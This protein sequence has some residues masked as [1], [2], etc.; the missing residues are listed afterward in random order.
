MTPEDII[1]SLGLIPHPEG[2]WYTETW[3]SDPEHGHRSAGTAIYFLL[4]A[5]E[6]SHWHRVDADETWHHYAGGPLELLIAPTVNGPAT[7]HILTGDLTMGRPQAVVPKGHWQAAQ[8][9]GDW[10][11]VGCTVSPGF[12]FAGFDLAMPDFDIP[13]ALPL[14]RGLPEGQRMR[15]AALFWDAFK[16]KLGPILGPRDKALAFLAPALQP[17]FAISALGTRGQLLGIA[18]IKT[19]DGGLLGGGFDDLARVYGRWGAAWRGAA[20][21]LFERRITPDVLLMDGIFVA[22]D[23][24]GMGIGGALLDAI[25]QEA[26]IRGKRAVRLDV[27]DDNQRARALYERKGFVAVETVKTG[28]LR[29][30]MGFASA[31]TM[32]RKVSPAN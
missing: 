20:L 9:L 29:H 4:R 6:R 13:R 7:A 21:S 28:P 10:A 11:L 8:P 30:I 26:A 19:A 12:D 2:G 16:G 5:G 24:R 23:A 14:L 22:E 15:A 31:T 1:A 17:G 32:E 27:I 18:G 3:R 25:T